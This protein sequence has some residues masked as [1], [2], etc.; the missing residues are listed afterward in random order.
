MSKENTEIVREFFRAWEG[1]DLGGAL[2]LLDP[3]VITLRGEKVTRVDM[4][5]S[6][7]QALEAAGLR[8]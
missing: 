4:Y 3:H 2:A 6:Q 8:E 1:G 5:M 7:A